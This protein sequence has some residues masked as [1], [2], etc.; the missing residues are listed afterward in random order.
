MFNMEHFIGETTV[1]RDAQRV[2]GV[3]PYKPV[4]HPQLSSEHK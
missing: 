3:P 1:C 4:L 2:T